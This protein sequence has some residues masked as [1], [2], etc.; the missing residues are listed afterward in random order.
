MVSIPGISSALTVCAVS[1]NSIAGN[2]ISQ[3]VRRVLFIVD[4]SHLDILMFMSKEYIKTRIKIC[5]TC[6][7]LLKPTYTCKE[8]GCFMRIKTR[9]KRAGCPLNKWEPEST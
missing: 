5:E 3:R 2:G 6:S 8:C 7:S 4:L 9:I 1:A